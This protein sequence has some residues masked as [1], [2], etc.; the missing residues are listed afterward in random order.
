MTGR[1]SDPFGAPF[2]LRRLVWSLLLILV[3]V[4]VA[5]CSLQTNAQLEQIRHHRGH[6]ATALAVV[7]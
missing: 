6:P 7:R 5:R 2:S 1:G 3:L 4:L